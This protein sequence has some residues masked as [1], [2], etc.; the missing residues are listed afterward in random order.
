MLKGGSVPES[1]KK[2]M[3]K[4][5]G[6]IP[7]SYKNKPLRSDLIF[8]ID[9]FFDLETERQNSFSIGYIPWSKIIEYGLFCKLEGRSLDRFVFL[10]RQL[11]NEY[12]AY[13]REKE[14]RDAKR[15]T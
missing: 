1:V 2:Q 4:F 11:D 3:L 7:D 10:I 15:S 9:A 12:V 14:K 6:S 5:N 8:F 13:K